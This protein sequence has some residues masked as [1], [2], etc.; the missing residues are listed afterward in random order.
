MEYEVGGALAGGGPFGFLDFYFFSVAVGGVACGVEVFVVGVEVGFVGYVAVAQG[1]AFGFFPFSCGVVVEDDEGGYSFCC[2]F[3]VGVFVAFLE[4]EHD[5][6]FVGAFYCGLA[7]YAGELY[8]VGVAGGLVFVVVDEGLGAGCEG[9]AGGDVLFCVFHACDGFV[10]LAEVDCSGGEYFYVEEAEYFDFFY[11][12][13]QAG[14]HS[15]VVVF[16]EDGG[17]CLI[18]SH[19]FGHDVGC[20]PGA[21]AEVG[22]GD[23]AADECVGAYF[24]EGLF[25]SAD[26]GAFFYFSLDPCVHVAVWECACA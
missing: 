15:V 8:A 7:A 20:G 17:V 18:D 23:S 5:Y 24:V 19:Y 13:F 16:G 26:D 6:A 25:V 21:L 2:Y 12:G 1:V 4:V 9:D 22:V 3:S 14:A 10:H 11:S